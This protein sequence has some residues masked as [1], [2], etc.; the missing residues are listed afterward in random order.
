MFQ[1]QLKLSTQYKQI[2]KHLSCLKYLN[3][4]FLFKGVK[5]PGLRKEK[6]DT[7][8]YRLDPTATSENDPELDDNILFFENKIP[9]RPQGD[10]LDNILKNWWGDYDRLEVHHGYI[11]WLFPL[12]KQGLNSR[13][14]PLQLHELEV[15]VLRLI[16]FFKR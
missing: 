5:Y 9:S 12:R 1:R 14:H 11:Q 3:Y 13:A 16:R 6:R 2:E 10:F 8:E 15:I 4:V 7:K